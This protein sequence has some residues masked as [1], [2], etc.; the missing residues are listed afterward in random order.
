[1]GS[2]EPQNAGTNLD[3]PETLRSAEAVDGVDVTLIRWMLTLTPAQRLEV[4]QQHVQA[5]MSLRDAIPRR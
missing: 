2:S 5:I 1:M 3:L 4:L